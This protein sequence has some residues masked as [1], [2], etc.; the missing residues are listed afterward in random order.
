MS[1]LR[2]NP[3]DLPEI[4]TRIGHFIP[5][6]VRNP[7]SRYTFLFQPQDLLSAIAVNR[8]FY[9]TL[10]PLLWTVYND[11][12][13]RSSKSNEQD[14][15]CIPFNVILANSHHFRFFENNLSPPLPDAN[16]NANARFNSR[17]LQELRLS[18]Y[19]SPEQATDLILANPNLL[20]LTWESP[21]TYEFTITPAI[22]QAL[23]SLRHIRTLRLTGWSQ[24][25]EE[26]DTNPLHRLRTILVN[27]SVHLQD[28]SLSFMSGLESITEW[29]VL[30]NLRTLTLD[31]NWEAN[32]ALV[33]L[34]RFCPALENLIIHADY[35]CDV[36]TLAPL[37]RDYCPKLSAI[38]CPNGFMMFQSG[39]LL[40]DDEYVTLIEECRPL[41]T[42]IFSTTEIET[43]SG[44]Q[45]LAERSAEHVS[46]L[47][48]FEMAIGWL[49]VTIA[50]A[51]LTHANYLETLE[52]F[53][54]G[55]EIENFENANR[56]LSICPHLKRFA[57][58]NYLLEWNPEDGMLLFQTPWACRGI[59]VFMLDG[60]AD[61]FENHAF[62]QEWDDDGDDN[63]DDP[64]INGQG[65]VVDQ[66]AQDS[67]EQED[68]V[69]QQLKDSAAE[70]DSGP[71]QDY[72]TAI[73][74]TTTTTAAATTT[75]TTAD[76]DMDA[77][78]NGGQGHIQEYTREHTQEEQPELEKD[79]DIP[80]I[81]QIV[82]EN[83]YNRDNH[84]QGVQG[85]AFK[86]M[87]FSF[88]ETM[89]NLITIELNGRVR[90]KVQM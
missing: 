30:P 76:I 6:W 19:F 75:E 4:L 80:A 26:G 3:L 13:L 9:V 46:G 84:L 61:P 85:R 58:C 33:H 40:S 73:A 34:V 1:S 59:E 16:A 89:P 72:A 82:G 47:K 70:P 86:R 53:I 24:I 43:G 37:L 83:T 20:L 55:D 10:T 63:G 90:E 87:L 35:K 18:R 29:I 66:T 31:N 57:L 64:V 78:L 17:N 62:Y 77:N 32:P 28:L 8:H 27:N 7:R 23:L 68:V 74:T 14:H 12:V 54:C 65:S 56:L 22:Y 51:L 21:L 15:Y 48:H 45:A 44:V 52:L 36:K 79:D 41:S 39:L 69:L 11:Y 88:A 50:N 5:L 2:P 42:R 81:W 67:E 25:R 60:F 71:E 38:R 49:D